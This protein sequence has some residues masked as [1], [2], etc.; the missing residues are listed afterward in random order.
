VYCIELDFGLRLDTAPADLEDGSASGVRAARR[1]GAA[2]AALRAPIQAG[3]TLHV[4][5]QCPA[6]RAGWDRPISIPGQENAMRRSRGFSLIE[7]L[8]VVAIISLLV[9][10]TMPSFKEA[11]RLARKTVCQKNLQSIGQGTLAYL[12]IHQDTFP[13]VCRLP[14]Y[15]AEAAS[16]AGRDPYV[17]LPKAL[18]QEMKGKSEVYLCP[19]DRNLKSTDTIHAERYYDNEGIS[20]EWESRLNG[21]HISYKN[22]RLFDG[23]LTPPPS[24]VWMLYDFEAYHGGEAVRGSLN[25]LYVD[26]HVRSDKSKGWAVGEIPTS[27]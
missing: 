25:V 6:G 14:S 17:P 26:L 10:I 19:A 13:W 4:T 20:Y 24:D 21:I 9:G 7:L 11:R 2:G 18:V 8:V 27:W 12:Q 15:E 23:L 1:S 3:R 16:D 22:M 5:W